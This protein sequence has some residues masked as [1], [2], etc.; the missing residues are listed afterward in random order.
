M[1]YP[2]LDCHKMYVA[3]GALD[4]DSSRDW[5]YPRIRQNTNFP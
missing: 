5:Q 4:G 3:A 1:R 2:G